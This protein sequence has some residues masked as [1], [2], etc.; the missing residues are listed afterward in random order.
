MEKI[1]QWQIAGAAFTII[2]GTLLHFVYEWFGGPVWA[3]L[4]PVNESTWEHLKLI[5]WPAVLFA[6][7]EYLVYGR[8]I[9]G[10]IPVRVTSVIIGMALIVIMFYTYSGI[11]GRNILILDIMVFVMA[12]AGMHIFSF[13]KLKNPGGLFTSAFSSSCEVSV[14]AVICILMA[15]FV[16][17]PPE[18]GLFQD[19]V[20]GGFGLTE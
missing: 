12:A 4:G 3:V 17:D 5:F 10:F 6:A 20:T 18:I 19:P 8:R 2:S 16:Y 15:V 9:E 11:L 1:R 7:A 14:I 13:Y